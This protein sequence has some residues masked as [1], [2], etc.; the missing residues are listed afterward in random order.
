MDDPFHREF[1]FVTQSITIG[2]FVLGDLIGAGGMGRVFRAR[3]SGSDRDV[4]LKVI[5]DVGDIH[6]Q[7][8][9][10][11]REVQAHARLVHPGVVQLL[12]YG[13]IDEEAARASE[14]ELVCGSPFV[15]MELSEQGTIEDLQPVDDWA[16]V[17]AILL[18]VL[19]ALAFAH[20]RG[21][22]HRDLKP[23]NILRFLADD[24]EERFKLMDFGIAHARGTEDLREEQSL[25]EF[26][27]TP[28]YMAPEQVRSRWRDYGPHT[29][30]YSVGCIGYELVCG[31]PPFRGDNAIAV[32]LDQCT[33]DRPPLEP[34]FAVPDELEA[35][36]HRAMAVNPAIRFQRAAAAA[37]H[38]PGPGPT[39]R[40]AAL[41][42]KRSEEMGLAPTC[43][44]TLR[45][46][47]GEGCNDSAD[48]DEL[49]ASGNQA[50]IQR[51]IRDD[52]QA[53]P[54]PTTWR[55]DDE[56]SPLT[57][58]TAGLG[59]FGVRDIPF[60]DRDEQRDQLWALLDE[61][62]RDETFRV[63]LIVGEPGVGKSRLAR[64]S[65][66][67]AHE[68]GCV[69][70]P[71]MLNSPSGEGVADGFP[72]ILRRI[73]HAWKLPRLQLY[74]RLVEHLPLLGDPVIDDHDARAL[75]ELIQPVKGRGEVA[76]E[77]VFRF[78][79]RRQKMD[80]LTRLLSRFSLFRPP[81]MWFDDLQWG[82]LPRDW[83]EYVLGQG[84]QAPP[85]LIIATLRR[86]YL[87]DRPELR[88]WLR[89]VET[90]SMVRRIDLEPL[91]EK[92]HGALVHSML[93][94]EPELAHRVVAHTE[95]NP[96]FAHQ[97]LDQWVGADCLRESDD[98]LCLDD[99]ASISVPDELHQ[100]WSDRIKRLADHYGEDHRD[101]VLIAIELAAALGRNV[102]S[103][104]WDDLCRRRGL[105]RPS[106]LADDLMSRGLA[107]QVDRDWAFAHGLLVE[108]IERIS[109]SADRLADH[110]RLCA[111]MLEARYRERRSDIAR[112]LA[113]HWRFAGEPEHALEPLLERA[114]AHFR[115][116][117]LDLRRELL[118]L[119]EELLDE[120]G[121]DESDRRRLENELHLAH[122]TFSAGRR[123]E[124]IDKAT[125]VLERCR[126]AGHR[127]LLV[128]ASIRL[129]RFLRHTGSINDSERRLLAAHDE[130]CEGDDPFLRAEW[131]FAM[132]WA[133]QES[134]DR[135]RVRELLH[136]ARAL[137]R[138]CGRTYD[139]LW[140]EISLAWNDLRFG[141][142]EEAEACFKAVER[143]ADEDGFARLCN[144]SRNGLAEVAR[145]KG[146]LEQA[147]RLYEI[148]LAEEQRFGEVLGESYCL[149]NLGMVDVVQRRFE[150]LQ[151]RIAVMTQLG[152]EESY[153][154]CLQ[155]AYAA[156]VGNW[157][158]LAR[159]FTRFHRE[160]HSDKRISDDFPWLLELVAQFCEDAGQSA[161][162]AT[163]RAAVD[164][165]KRRLGFS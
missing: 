41:S 123:D 115:H 73:F 91:E 58:G 34:L 72:G 47:L 11:Q 101:G 54:F 36:I 3:V 103:D 148:C 51:T 33:A 19:D 77:P 131:S 48:A 127:R 159:H 42:E 68:V 139:R 117:E 35:W 25:A 76:E 6:A 29:D 162:A 165:M 10:F 87:A 81:V 22:F 13:E 142:H 20:A 57:I 2:P 141:R 55:T 128:E 147:R 8:E 124:A 110:H 130:L 164:E 96:L 45:W 153:V 100:L 146:D 151:A 37:W 56:P 152:A 125:D 163:L 32:A 4:A 23:A 39:A 137:Y 66:T 79:E 50:A 85:G 114:E 92:F 59:L 94:L 78:E 118:R 5:G 16:A 143:A 12:D 90:S 158:G 17:R 1:S 98:G 126:R 65:V 161:H 135:E 53:M 108:S 70:T 116:G 112:R 7:R 156:G 71:R 24:G 88:R 60:V 15:A 121:A 140:A 43:L 149:F 99:A 52:A 113:R 150:D 21:V 14:G 69:V 67:R 132:A 136:R 155:I 46:C 64:W 120:M 109:E 9:R 18:Q 62:H 154:L 86:D 74:E 122:C 30:I 133:L 89:D 38:L 80:V 145:L 93:P 106:S 157:D 95:G 49:T 75:T 138:V 160:I 129:S 61:V 63:A 28:Y 104:E 40:L 119:R 27:G 26:S 97:L 107:T 84:E 83:I 102:S 134:G 105:E 44:Q 111:E 82:T 31:R 144:E